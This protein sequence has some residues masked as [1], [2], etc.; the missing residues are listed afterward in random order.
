[1]SLKISYLEHKRMHSV[2]LAFND[3][4]SPHHSHISK[5]SKISNPELHRGS[6]RRVKNKLLSQFI[7][8]GGSLN[9]SYIW[10]VS[11]LCESVASK[12]LEAGS[13]KQNTL[14]FLS[15]KSFNSFAVESKM[16][17]ISN[18]GRDIKLEKPAYLM[19]IVIYILCYLLRGDVS[20]RD[21][22]ISKIEQKLHR[23]SSQRL[24]I[25]GVIRSISNIT[26]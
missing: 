12:P 7:K 6:C 19:S 5:P 3:Q 18:S 16:D 22:L 2:V 8:C 15:S 14:M 17:L 21:V 26:S 24:F 11:K 23:I 20:F 9:A 10:S 4:L 13:I 25:S 1:M